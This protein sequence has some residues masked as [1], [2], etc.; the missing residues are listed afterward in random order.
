[1]EPAVSREEFSPRPQTCPAVGIP[2]QIAC[3]QVTTTGDPSQ[4]QERVSPTTRREEGAVG[5]DSE[6]SIVFGRFDEEVLDAE[7]IAVPPRFGSVP[8]EGAQVLPVRVQDAALGGVSEI[9]Q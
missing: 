6:C 3:G 1:M 2:R 5:F 7:A 9:I 4:K 8:M